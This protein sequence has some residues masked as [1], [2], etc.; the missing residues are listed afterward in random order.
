MNFPVERG[1]GLASGL[2]A[3]PR[4]IN[5]KT[6]SAAF[7]AFLFSVTGPAM[8]Y[9]ETA[10]AIGFTDEQAGAWLFGCFVLGGT[11]GIISALYYRMP[12]CGA[13]CIPGATLLATAL[14]GA[15]YAQAMGT[16][17]FSGLLVLL[18]GLTGATRRLMK[19]IPLPVVMGMVAG[20]MMQYAVNIVLNVRS[21]PLFCGAAVLGYLLTPRISK[22]LPAMLGAL[23]FSAA[24]LLLFDGISPSEG[25]MGLTAVTV[26]LPRWSGKYFLSASVPL[27]ILVV[28]AQN[29]QAIGVLQ[30][31][32][33]DPPVNGMTVFSGLASVAAGL[34]GAHNASVAGPMTA[35]CAA[36]ETGEK[37]S[38]FAA[39]VLAG[40]LCVLFGIFSGYV[41]GFTRCIPAQLVNTLAGLGLIGVLINALRGGFCSGRFSFGA[42]AAFAV[43]MSGLTVF[44]IGA[45]FWGILIGTFVSLAVESR[46]FASR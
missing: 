9:I 12:I 42:F 5:G 35:I 19:L 33:Y 10:R 2:R 26:T 30:T 38:R 20:C 41:I 1:P 37:D 40:A 22:K 25:G 11:L 34:L 28:G 44:G 39:S 29:A 6:L 21:A 14:Q 4:A 36:E 31:E 27:A 17:V 24:T 45:A 23:V 8:M 13:A 32:D 18:I 3:L 15:S 16:F 46:D 7:V 43:G